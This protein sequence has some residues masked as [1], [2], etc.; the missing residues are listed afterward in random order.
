[1]LH[2]VKQ[3]QNFIIF[4]KNRSVNTG[5]RQ[6]DKCV[7]ISNY[8]NNVPNPVSGNHIFKIDSNIN[9]LFFILNL[10][11]KSQNK[12]VLEFCTL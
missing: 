12:F 1:M 7:Q 4:V 6:L 3:K 5:N 10:L 9:Y 2:S 11:A 8:A